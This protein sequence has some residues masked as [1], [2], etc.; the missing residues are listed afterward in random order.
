MVKKNNKIAFAGKMGSGKDTASDY[1]IEKY[2]GT[3]VS[4]ASPI[5]DIMN[6]AQKTCGFELEKD[7]KFL[8]IVGSEW[9]REKNPSVWIDILLKK[10]SN[11]HGNFFVSDLRYNKELEVLKKEKWICVKIVRTFIDKDREGT[12]SIKHES[13]TSLDNVI[14]EKWDYVIE[15]NS[16]IESFYAQLD[17][18]VLS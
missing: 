18:I 12:G 8:Q 6:F 10:T 9:A 5:Y 17:K 14:N 7:R 11:K 13:E 15:N 4:F 1:M 3:K 16:S 2:K